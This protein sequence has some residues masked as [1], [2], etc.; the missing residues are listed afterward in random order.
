MG[1]SIKDVIYKQKYILTLTDQELSG[2]WFSFI[3]K[4][5]QVE[6][7]PVILKNIE[8]T[9]I[10]KLVNSRTGLA[11]NR[12]T[13]D[14]DIQE[15]LKKLIKENKLKPINFR[16]ENSLIRLY[17]DIFIYPKVPFIISFFTLK[18]ISD[19]N[20]S[21]FSMYFVFDLDI[22]GLEGFDNDYS[23]YDQE[24]DTIYQY[25]KTGL[26]A[27]FSTISKSTQYESV[28]TKD[29][30]IDL[31]QLNLSN[32]LYDGAGEI[33]SALQIEFKTLEPNQ[34]F[35]TALILSGGYTKDELIQNIVQG[36]QKAI[37][38]L[39]QVNRS[40]KSEQRNLQEEAFIK[41]NQQKAEDCGP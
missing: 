40:I 27:G 10:Y 14:F 28:L 7:V 29:F 3:L 13:L 39:K 32:T 36:K 8:P 23:G 6:R 11:I 20:L 2:P 18:N 17:I 35:Q 37:K 31:D 25:D 30:R 34:S 15:Y 19:Y 41:I 12:I 38:Y 9:P 21:D 33:L 5:K 1:F 26:H 4:G 16:K 22:N 24:F